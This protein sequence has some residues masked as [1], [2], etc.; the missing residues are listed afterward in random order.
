MTRLEDLI[1]A[2]EALTRRLMEA[3]K[4]LTLEDQYSVLTSFLSLE[5]LRR[6]VEFQER[7]EPK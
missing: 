5:D 6:L 3:L 7:E 1:A 4:H 2:R